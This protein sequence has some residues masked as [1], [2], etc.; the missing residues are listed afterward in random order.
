MTQGT[1]LGEV[2]SFTHKPNVL[3]LS[4]MLLRDLTALSYQSVKDEG[5]T[6]HKIT[7]THN[8]LHCWPLV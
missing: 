1:G 3:Y 4:T 7:Q 5:S 2:W 8:T 6:A